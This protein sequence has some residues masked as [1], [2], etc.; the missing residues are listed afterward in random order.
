V[1]EDEFD[2]WFHGAGFHRTG[3]GTDLIEEWSDGTRNIYI[4]RPSQMTAADRKA[5]IER[6]KMYLGID[7]N[8]RWG[9]H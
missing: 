2:A 1:S 9:V 4:T 7:Y 8:G 5:A 6:A 3:E